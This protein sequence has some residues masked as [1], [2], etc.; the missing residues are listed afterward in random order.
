MKS[1]CYCVRDYIGGEGETKKLPHLKWE[2]WHCILLILMIC[3]SN[4][5]CII[6]N[7]INVILTPNSYCIVLLRK[8]NR[9]T[10]RD[11]QKFN[12]QS[13]TILNDPFSRLLVYFYIWLSVF[14]NARP[15]QHP[16][17]NDTKIL[18]LFLKKQ[19]LSVW[20]SDRRNHVNGWSDQIILK[21]KFCK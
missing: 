21:L 1:K 4:F 13:G 17:M 16:L 11:D 14:T 7:I 5:C 15:H 6:D 8:K 19:I 20:S 10:F 2:F 12:L 18:R 9:L 3:F